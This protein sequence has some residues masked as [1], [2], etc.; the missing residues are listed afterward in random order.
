M[1]SIAHSLLGLLLATGAVSA[2]DH[3]RTRDLEGRF[4]VEVVRTDVG[5]TLPAEVGLDVSNAGRVRLEIGTRKFRLHRSGKELFGSMPASLGLASSLPGSTHATAV[6]VILKVKSKDLLEG[7]I[8]GGTERTE[9]RLRRV[10]PPVP[11]PEVIAQDYWGHAPDAYFTTEAAWQAWYN[12]TPGGPVGKWAY[13]RDQNATV[14]NFVLGDDDLWIEV[15][16][17]TKA[18][19]AIEVIGEH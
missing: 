16:E 8:K 11:S 13:L 9:V 2:Q 19:G 17:V 3:V 7:V 5:R 6:M 12:G 15:I 1:R 10:A 4:T 14:A 18:T